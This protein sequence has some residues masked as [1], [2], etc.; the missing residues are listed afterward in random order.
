MTQNAGDCALQLMQMQDII[1][2]ASY[3]APSGY[4][5]RHRLRGAVVYIFAGK[6]DM[7]LFF[8]QTKELCEVMGGLQSGPSH[9]HVLVKAG[10]D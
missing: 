4:L 7:A 6:S 10:S 5:Q 9:I 2:G 1:N 8:F 3:M